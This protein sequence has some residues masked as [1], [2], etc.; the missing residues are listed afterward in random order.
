MIGRAH[1]AEH[2]TNINEVNKAVETFNVINRGYPNRL[3]NLTAFPVLSGGTTDSACGGQLVPMTLTSSETGALSNAGLTNMYTLDTSAGRDLVAAPY[4]GTTTA[5]LLSTA[6]AGLDSV[7]ATRLYNLTTSSS[8][9]YVVFGLGSGC[10]MIGKPGGMPE[11]PLHF[12]DEKGAGGDPTKTY[13]RFGLVFR[14]SDTGG[15]ALERAQFVGAV[16]FHEDGVT[17]GS[18]AAA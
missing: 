13:A 14:V 17:N 5:A 3:D 15:I 1:T 2:A 6:V 4:G 7:A 12:S 18:D 11:A 9:K 10:E 16:A 8:E